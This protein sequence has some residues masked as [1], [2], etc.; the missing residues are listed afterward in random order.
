MKAFINHLKRNRIEN[1]VY[2]ALWIIIFTAPMMNMYVRVVNVAELYFLW[3]EIIDMWRY[4]CMFLVAFIINN[5]FLN[6]ILIKRRDIHLYLCMAVL[7]LVVFTAFQSF[8]VYFFH[9]TV[10]QVRDSVLP[11]LPG[12][13]I[14]IVSTVVLMLLMGMN[15]GV[16][17][18]FK[19]ERDSIEMQL[20]ENQNLEHQLAY[21]RYQINPH[22][23]MNTLNNIHALVDINPEK[24]KATIVELSK[25][26]RY[27]LYDANRESVSLKKEIEFLRHY[28]RLMSLRFTDDIKT[29]LTVPERMTDCNVPPLLLIIFAETAYKHGINY[30][31]QS[32]VEVSI[33]VVDGN[34]VF[35]CSNSKHTAKPTCEKGGVGLVN[36]RKRLDLLY[37]TNYKL[38][39]KDS[40][41]RFDVKLVM[42][43]LKERPQEKTVNNGSDKNG[44]QG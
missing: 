10:V 12:A 11:Q 8:M 28:F 20:V 4:T 42:P 32:F 38:E 9:D 15:L 23:Y 41:Q 5:A 7:L 34:V 39:I 29:S 31:G 37:D 30:S 26:L 1:L 44:K 25:M 18:F 2:L 14:D 40:E 16:K 35:T 43:V 24:A 27:V 33:D 22:F 19:L 21:L 17:L 36:V 3:D 6:D 13:S